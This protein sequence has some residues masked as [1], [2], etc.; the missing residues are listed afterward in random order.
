[1]QPGLDR[2][3]RS[4][5]P[6]FVG[7]RSRCRCLSTVSSEFVPGTSRAPG[8]ASGPP[9]APPGS[10]RRRRAPRAA[11][12]PPRPARP[13]CHSPP[14]RGPREPPP[15]PPPPTRPRGS[16]RAR[17]G[18]GACAEAPADWL[19]PSRGRRPSRDKGTPHASGRAGV[20]EWSRVRFPRQALPGPPSGRCFS[21]AF[22][23]A[24]A[25]SCSHPSPLVTLHRITEL[26]S[27]PDRPGA[28]SCRLLA[29]RRCGPRP[30]STLLSGSSVQREGHARASLLQTEHSQLPR[31]LRTGL[32]L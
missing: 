6:V 9:R 26:L 25:I 30:G 24:K 7:S 3:Q 20:T 10:A 5:T 23:V 17:P 16:E 18:H 4:D 8:A 32:V 2:R 31:L 13:P 11:P 12:A 22:T 21:R 28:A 29:G 14:A 27:N 19:R 15:P 1:M